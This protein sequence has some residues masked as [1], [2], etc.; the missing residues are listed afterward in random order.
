MKG[1][2]ILTPIEIDRMGFQALCDALGL[3]GA[4]RFVRQTGAGS[5]DYTRERGTIL[6]GLTMGDL[7]RE[8][9][10][11]ERKRVRRKK[12]PLLHRR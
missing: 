5:G 10:K 4:L 8:A 1:A 3:A 12:L 6:H 2:E 11:F 9:R 7:A